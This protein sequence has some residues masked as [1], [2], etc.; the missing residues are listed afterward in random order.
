MNV[1][2]PLL[3]AGDVRPRERGAC[4]VCPPPHTTLTGTVPLG[5]PDPCWEVL[6]ASAVAPVGGKEQLPLLPLL[7]FLGTAHEPVPSAPLPL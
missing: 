4:E 2:S 5:P 3:K 7:L 1:L 6:Q